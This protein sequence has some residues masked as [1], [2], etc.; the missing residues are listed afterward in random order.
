VRRRRSVVRGL[1]WASFAGQAAFVASWLIGGA[2]EPHYSH[3]EQAISELAASNAAHPAIETAGLAAFGLA[4]VALAVALWRV[5]PRRPARLVACGLFAA[6]GG[7]MLA[8]AAFPLDCGVTVD[9]HCRALSDAGR[10]SWQHYAHMWTSFGAEL[11]LLAT[12][13]ALAAALWPGTVAAAALGCGTFGVGVGALSFISYGADGHADGLI[14]R[15]D[16]GVLHVWLLIVGIGVLYA[17]RGA[18]A[19]GELIA[20]RPRDVLARAWT[21]EGELVLRPLALGRLFAQRFGARREATW[22]SDR[23][24]RIDDEASFPGGRVERRAM[25]CEFLADDRVRLTAGDLPDG[26]D[27]TLEAGGFRVTDFRVAYPIG[28]LPVLVSCRDRSRVEPDGTFVNAID[29]R[30]PGIPIPLARVTF[31][32]RVDEADLAPAGPPARAPSLV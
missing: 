28:P 13:F 18:P 10:L 29:V 2:A 24:W 23:V 11:L 31:R 7:A 21:G 26:A 19:R 17:T 4:L 9:L 25:Y 8:A 30:A 32:V 22:I 1:V 6:A 3:V 15:C 12:P 20:L 16:L 14:Q 27:V 5:L